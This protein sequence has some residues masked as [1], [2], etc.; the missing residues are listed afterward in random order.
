MKVRITKLRRLGEVKK[1]RVTITVNGKENTYDVDSKKQLLHFL[2][3]D[4]KLTGT[5]NGCGVG[6]CGSCTV[7]IDNVPKR[8]CITKLSQCDGKVIETIEGLGTIDKLHPLQQAFIEEGAVQCGFCTPGMLMTGKALLNHNPDPTLQDIRF[9]YRHNLCRCTG[10]G[11]IFR[12]IKKAAAVLRGENPSQDEL[13]FVGKLNGK[14]VNAHRSNRT[15]DADVQGVGTNVIK[16]DAY[17]KVTGGKAFAGDYEEKNQ[18]VGK[19]LLSS[20]AHATIRSIDTSEAK[21][22]LGVVGVVTY[23]DI[24][25]LNKFGLFVPQ[26]PVLVESEVKFFGDVIACV[27]AETDELASVAVQKIKV[28]Y[29]VLPALLDPE[30]SLLENAPLIHDDLTTNIIH[31]VAVSKGDVNLGF[32]QADVIIENVYETQAVEHAYLE[33][34]ACLAIPEDD[35]IT[36]YSGSQG[37]HAYRRMIAA[38]LDIDVEKVRV[39]LTATGGG[40]GGKEEPTNQILAA[41]GAWLTQRP[42]KMVLTREESIRMSTKRH[43]MK[44]WMKHG[45]TRDGRI[46]AMTSKV[47]ADGG[48]YVSQTHPV[49]FRSAVTA[50]GPY[51]VE[52]VEANSYGVYTHKNPS[53]AFRGF[54][55]TQASFACESQMDQLAEAIGMSPYE[56]RKKNGFREGSITSTGQ[57]LKD[58]IGYLATLNAVNESLETMKTEFALMERPPHIKLGFGLGCAYK[59]VGIGTG[60]PDKAGAYVEVLE[61]GRV[62]VSMGAA[63]IGQGS[64]TIMAQIAATALNISY[65]LIDVVACD[66]K[67]CPDGGMT[68]ASRQTFVTGN[69]VKEGALIL[70]ERITSVIEKYDKSTLATPCS[71]VIVDSRRLKDIF[72]WAKLEPKINLRVEHEY[73]PPKTFVHKVDANHKAGEALDT[74]DIHYA[75]CFASAAVALEVNTE[76]GEVKVLKVA[77]AQ[78]V[79]KALHPVNIIGQIEGSVAMGVGLALTEE[80]VVDDVKLHQIT[81]KSLGILSSESIPDIESHIIEEEQMKGP[82]GA[83][84]MGEVGLNPVAPAIANAIYDA[85]NI[86]LTSLPMKPHKVLEAL[87]RGAEQVVKQE[88]KQEVKQGGESL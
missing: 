68:T 6:Q 42:V 37:S 34:E 53:G 30:M 60:K 62:L 75:Y 39:V 32:S 44:L 26:Q 78:D 8:S 35:G 69:A 59:N 47:I 83:K 3:D 74:Y 58:G 79:G 76:T 29:D 20:H 46:V 81:L 10:Y 71:E 45:I 73:Y 24:E 48:A 17:I 16:K 56:L 38:T 21:S 63:D 4:L 50:S 31:H 49:I 9:A 87:K 2:R 72:A 67:I 51:I 61:T 13:H 40:F 12:A 85:A 55:S 18:L 54:G 43:P 57:V 64:D 88:V 65:D 52:N 77:A 86:R 70:R 41:L 19:I 11:A 66:T 28:D 36:L 27:Y 22:S 25:G 14:I 33:P 1:M 84:G 82:Y 7:L 23:R 5:K 15:S 80:F